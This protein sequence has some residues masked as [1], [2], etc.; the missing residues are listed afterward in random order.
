MKAKEILDAMI[1]R[2][3][4][5]PMN[6]GRLS[7]TV[8]EPIYENGQTMIEMNFMADDKSKFI[9]KEYITSNDSE[10]LLSRAYSAMLNRILN[11]IYDRMSSDT[12]FTQG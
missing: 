1:A 7:Y 12:F 6:V 4:D 9:V 11:S 10:L 2:Q 8:S 3:N 5:N